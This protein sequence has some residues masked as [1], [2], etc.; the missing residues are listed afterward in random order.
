MDVRRVSNNNTPQRHL[1]LHSRLQHRFMIGGVSMAL[2]LGKLYT[3]FDTKS[4]FI[5]STVTFM[6]ASA[7]CGAAPTMNASDQYRST[8]PI[9]QGS[10]LGI[11]QKKENNP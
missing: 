8:I 9:A 10:V 4:L 3:F 5:V 1:Q 7:L 6:A 11:F 2:I